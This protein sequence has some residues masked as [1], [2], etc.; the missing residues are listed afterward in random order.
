MMCAS[1]AQPAQ[2]FVA[3]KSG[4]L[5]A[6]VAAITGGFVPALFMPESDLKSMV[7]LYVLYV[8]MAMRWPQSARRPSR[9]DIVYNDFAK[10]SSRLESHRLVCVD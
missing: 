8:V 3:D 4:G 5:L 10:F 7:V 1:P 6:L 9:V 2:T